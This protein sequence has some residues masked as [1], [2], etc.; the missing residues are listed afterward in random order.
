[1]ATTVANA[2]SEQARLRSAALNAVI[3]EAMPEDTETGAVLRCR[4]RLAAVG[5]IWKP[6]A[7]DAWQP[8]IPSLMAYIA[9]LE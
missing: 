9:A 5:Y 2:F 4:D 3:A 6:P 8:G 1:M 7:E